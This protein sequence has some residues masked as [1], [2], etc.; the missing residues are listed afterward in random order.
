[1]CLFLIHINKEVHPSMS[2]IIRRARGEGGLINFFWLVC[3]A[4]ILTKILWGSGEWKRVYK[5]DVIQGANA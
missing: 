5:F 3:Q 1:M 2:S 4:I